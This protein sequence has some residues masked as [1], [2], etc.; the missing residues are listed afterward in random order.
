[1]LRRV[2]LPR[3]RTVPLLALLGGLVVLG[4]ATRVAF[5]GGEPPRPCPRPALLGDLLV[6]DGRGDPA[7]ARAWLAGERLDLRHARRSDVEALPG[8]GAGRAAAILSLIRAR[9]GLWSVRELDDVPGIG[10]KTLAR[11]APLV[12]VSSSVDSQREASQGPRSRTTTVPKAA[13]SSPV[14]RAGSPSSARRR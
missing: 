14:V 13:K 3:D 8:I 1:M 11:I 2:R 6:C 7:G 10:P 4:A 9:G 5:G 12:R